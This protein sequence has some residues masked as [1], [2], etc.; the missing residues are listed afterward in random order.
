MKKSSALSLTNWIS[1][2]FVECNTG[3]TI[4]IYIN[5]YIL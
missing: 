3:T 4:I 2:A 1:T 5:Q